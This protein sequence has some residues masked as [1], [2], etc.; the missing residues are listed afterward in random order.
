[1]AKFTNVT[2]TFNEWLTMSAYFAGAIGSSTARV[3][4]ASVSGNQ[5]KAKSAARDLEEAS[6][7]KQMLVSAKERSDAVKPPT[8]DE[9]SEASAL[10][11]EAYDWLA[12][13][14]EEMGGADGEPMPPEEVEMW[15]NG[16]LD[17]AE[18]WTIQTRRR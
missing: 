10:I 12:N 1:M 14:L 2:I 8:I 9:L 11:K 15:V 17:K 16:W 6:K 13:A 5:I 4:M 7:L 3:T 18:K